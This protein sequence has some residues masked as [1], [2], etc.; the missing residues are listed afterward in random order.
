MLSMKLI[1]KTLS[2]LISPGELCKW[3]ILI[4]NGFWRQ[5][6]KLGKK[7]TDIGHAVNLIKRP[8]YMYVRMLANRF[9]LHFIT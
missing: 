2:V 9:Q 3:L 6:L 8:G 5:V 7:K 1:L 4:K